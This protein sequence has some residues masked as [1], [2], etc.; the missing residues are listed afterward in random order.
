[1]AVQVHFSKE[2]SY[3]SYIYDQTAGVWDTPVTVELN[4][5]KTNYIEDTKYTKFRQC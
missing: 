3:Y 4:L 1:M 2:H 5:K